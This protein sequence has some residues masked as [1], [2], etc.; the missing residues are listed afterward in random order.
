M[1]RFGDILSQTSITVACENPGKY[2]LPKGGSLKQF[3]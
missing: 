1:S 3:G 2:I